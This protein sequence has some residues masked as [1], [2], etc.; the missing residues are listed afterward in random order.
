M[1]ILFWYPISS[2]SFALHDY[3]QPS[4]PRESE[5][6]ARGV[7][8]ESK[9]LTNQAITSRP[10]LNPEKRSQRV[11]TLMSEASKKNGEAS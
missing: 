9:G 10:R 4:P 6:K 8:F 11:E 3:L 5:Q 2:S 1:Q 7:F